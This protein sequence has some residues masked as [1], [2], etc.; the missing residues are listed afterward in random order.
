LILQYAIQA[1]GQQ[2]L[3]ARLKKSCSTGKALY[4]D[5]WIFFCPTYYLFGYLI[6][7][8]Q[9]RIET[10]TNIDELIDDVIEREGGYVN[11]PVD[12]GAKVM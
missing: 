8:T 9:E 6:R 1:V 10:M 5:K 11:H 3:I 2:D 4:L 12:R 7:L